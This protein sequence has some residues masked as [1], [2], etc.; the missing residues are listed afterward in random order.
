MRLL[1]LHLTVIARG[2]LWSI[3][4]D[5]HLKVFRFIFDKQA[6]VD[7]E[8]V[9][10]RADGLALISYRVSLVLPYIMLGYSIGIIVRIEYT[11]AV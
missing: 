3:I 9:G 8:K 4:H 11:L 7:W 10:R 6:R 1:A 5:E 2:S